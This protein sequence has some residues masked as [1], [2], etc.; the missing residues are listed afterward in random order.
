MLSRWLPVSILA[1]LAA[2]GGRV[3]DERASPVAVEH[4]ARFSGFWM[5]EE[6]A[7]RGGYSAAIFELDPGGALALRHGFASSGSVEALGRVFKD[8]VSCG[9]GAGWR[10]EGDGVLVVD[11]TCSDGVGREIRIQ[12]TNEPSTNT[13]GAN[14]L[15]VS[16]GRESG[17]ERRGFGWKMAKCVSEQACLSKWR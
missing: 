6:E 3:D 1:A 15:I 13:R 9:F 10:S 17:W 11:G 4:S 14:A 2:C 16:V 8:A 12:L 5:L 7:V